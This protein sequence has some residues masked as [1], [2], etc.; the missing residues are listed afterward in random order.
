MPALVVLA[1]VAS[2]G[3]SAPAADEGSAHALLPVV[4]ALFVVV[5]AATLGGAVF[6]A[7]RLPAVLGEVCAG[8]A[9]G[10]L[11]L[12]GIR[13]L[14]FVRDDPG[15]DF[16]G[17]IGSLLLLFTVGLES[18]LA[19]LRSVGGAALRVA[20]LGVAVPLFAGW[21]VAAAWF[22][23]S[24]SLSQW[25]LGGVLTATSI[26]ITARVLADAR[27][28]A[29]LEGR[30]VLGAA[31]LDD[32]LGLLVLALIAGAIEARADGAALS[33]AGMLLVAAKCLGFV[34]VALFAG[35][36]LA[37]RWFALVARLP[38]EGTLFAGALAACLAGAWLAGAA[39][40]APIVGAFAAG[41]FIE[42]AHYE[43]LRARDVRGA[44]LEEMFGPLRAFLVPVFFV[45]MG[46]R[47]DLAAIARP[48]ILGFGVVLTVVGVAGKLASAGGVWRTG[49]D[50]WTV[51][52]GMLPRGEVGLIFA[53]VGSQLRVAGQ[54]VIGPE[55]FAAVVLMVTVTTLLTP[56]LLQAR[57]ARRSL[58]L[59]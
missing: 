48:D 39:G 37:G 43:R 29:S 31:V 33:A 46:M 55:V 19:A 54:P 4:G 6:S 41:L 57:L 20:V 18:Q 7:W 17:Q 9:L 51:G 13:E 27:Q 5:A 16:L 28:T 14:A 36:W 45:L 42:E 23:G 53:G 1:A 38:G 58:R 11:P 59:R 22:P 15:L 34:G 25:F 30:I 8:V 3:A 12:L 56:P 44:S 21:A 35:R 26:G 52:I 50:P 24:S 47:V 10:N 49:A 32:V 2:L 40:L